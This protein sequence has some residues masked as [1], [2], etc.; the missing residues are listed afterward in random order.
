MGCKAQRD[1]V[2]PTGLSPW[3]VLFSN[4][5]A[6]WHPCVYDASQWMEVEKKGEMIEMKKKKKVDT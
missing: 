5:S 4:L 6:R 3:Q 2:Q 1:H